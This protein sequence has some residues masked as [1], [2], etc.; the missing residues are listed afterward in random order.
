M[1]DEMKKAIFR[2]YS[3]H[4][5][6]FNTWEELKNATKI[7]EQKELRC[8]YCNDLLEPENK[9]DLRKV[10][11]LDHK[12]PKYWNGKDTIENTVLCCTECNMM[13]GTM[14]EKTYLEVIG[15]L[16]KAGIKKKVFEEA[17]PGRR[18]ATLSRK[19]NAELWELV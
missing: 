12:T 4:N 16:F 10:V 14:F 13:K 2:R 5:I 7:N 3:K 19:N 8:Y 15:L 6:K 11:S 1:N 17:F 18:A 9:N